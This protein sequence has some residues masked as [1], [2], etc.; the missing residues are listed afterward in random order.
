MNKQ[1]KQQS[2]T[3]RLS[4][5]D[6]RMPT[7]ELI[8]QCLAEAQKNPGRNIEQPFAVGKPVYT[9]SLACTFDPTQHTAEA[10]WTLFQGEGQY[11]ESLWTYQTGDPA[12]ILNLLL[13]ECQPGDEIKPAG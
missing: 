7:L 1:Q 4:K 8:G 11:R 5:L 6:R 9:Y 10:N 13:K 3:L 2:T 12:L